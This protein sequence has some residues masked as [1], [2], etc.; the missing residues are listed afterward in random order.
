MLSTVGDVHLDAARCEL[1]SFEG[2]RDKRACINR[3]ATALQVAVVAYQ[4]QLPQSVTRASMNLER[5][6]KAKYMFD[7]AS[8]TL[9]AC[10][11]YLEEWSIVKRIVSNHRSAV[12]PNKLRSTMEVLDAVSGFAIVAFRPGTYTYA[13]RQSTYSDIGEQDVES[14]MEAAQRLAEAMS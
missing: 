9:I 1:E 11:I 3:A 8:M 10:H 7:V 2:A 14:F 5:S 12:K 13:M 6:I 4:K